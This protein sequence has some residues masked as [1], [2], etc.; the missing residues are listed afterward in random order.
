VPDWLSNFQNSEWPHYYLLDN[1]LS[2]QEYEWFMQQSTKKNCVMGN[3]YYVSNEH[4]VH[5][6]GTTSAA[7][8]VFGYYAITRQY[9]GRYRLPIMHTE[10]NMAEPDA[11]FKLFH[12]PCL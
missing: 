10:T 8:D 5:H 4:M 3:D 6:D 1:G 11:K 12:N 2:R 7:G 9:F